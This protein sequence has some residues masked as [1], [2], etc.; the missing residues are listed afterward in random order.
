MRPWVKILFL[1]STA[2][3]IWEKDQINVF[4]LYFHICGMGTVIVPIGLVW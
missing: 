3:V 4:A 2:C 1:S